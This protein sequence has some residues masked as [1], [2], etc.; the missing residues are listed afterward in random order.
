MTYL[1]KYSLSKNNKSEVIYQGKNVN[2]QGSVGVATS[3]LLPLLF[4]HPY[5]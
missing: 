3:D 4:L 1:S 2:Y 5:G